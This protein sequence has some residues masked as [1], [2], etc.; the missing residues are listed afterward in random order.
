[1]SLEAPFEAKSIPN[2]VIDFF[3]DR[4]RTDWWGNSSLFFLTALL[5]GVGIF[6]LGV[7]LNASRKKRS[8][9]FPDLRILFQLPAT[10]RDPALIR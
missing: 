7:F 3:V 4:E 2:A 10:S 5:I 6:R 1:M 8:G 9:E